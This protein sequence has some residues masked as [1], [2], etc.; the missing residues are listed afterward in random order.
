MALEFLLQLPEAHASVGSAPAQHASARLVEMDGE[1]IV[2]SANRAAPP[3]AP[4]VLSAPEGDIFEARTRSC[5][6]STP[7]GEYVLEARLVNLSREARVRL[8]RF[9]SPPARPVSGQAKGHPDR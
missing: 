4:L 2:L 6:R 3:G 9:M 7:M 1:R 8:A 5:R